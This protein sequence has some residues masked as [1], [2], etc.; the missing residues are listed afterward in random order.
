MDKPVLSAI[1]STYNSEKFIKGKILDLLDQTVADKMEIIIINSGSQQNE[2][3]VIKEFLEYPNIHYIKTEERETIY[4]AWNRGIKVAKG[5]FITNANTDDRLKKDALEILVNALKNNPDAALVYADQYISEVPNQ[6]FDEVLKV[7]DKREYNFPDYNYF[8]QLGRCLISSQSVWRASLH[9]EDNIW[10]DDKYEVCG[11]YD[12]TMKVSQKYPL[13]HLKEYLGVFY[14][15]PGKENKSFKESVLGNE[16]IH[17]ISEPRIRSYVDSAD[18]KEVYGLLNEMKRILMLPIPL[19]YFIKR[20]RL[21]LRPD[22]DKTVYIH[23]IE[24]VYFLSMLL[25][26]KQNRKKDAVRIGKKFNRYGK[27]RRIMDLLSEIKDQ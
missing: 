12:F 5:D 6:T 24:F 22:S 15:S 17:E 25:F 3:L 14:L 21:I 13:L 27:S 18:N 26:L 16:E 19:F 1:I 20:I 2:D 8:N 10:F 23:S 7:Q 4:K 9:F 11:D